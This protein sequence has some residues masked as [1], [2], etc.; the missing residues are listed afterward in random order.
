MKVSE[1]RKLIRE[2]VKHVLTQSLNEDWGTDDIKAIH[3]EIDPV[4]QETLKKA[5]GKKTV[6]ISTIHFSIAGKTQR[7]LLKMTIPGRFL[8]QKL[9]RDTKCP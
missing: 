4:K 3:F 2:Q 8:L 7:N 9:L 5:Y 1:L 6:I